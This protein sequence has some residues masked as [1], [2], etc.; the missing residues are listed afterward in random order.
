[1]FEKSWRIHSRQGFSLIEL[2]VVVGIVAILAGLLLP[3]LSKARR[4]VRLSQCFNNQRQLLLTWHLYNGDNREL[5]VANG[6]GQAGSSIALSS[7]MN[8]GAAA[9]RFWVPGD[10]HF[11]YPAFTNAQWLTDPRNAMFAP[12]LRSAVVYK[13][14][15]DHSFINV[16][17]VGKFPHIRS[18]S[19]NAYVGWAVTP[20]E[21]NPHYRVFATT[22][23]MVG[24]SSP[25]SLFVFQDVHPDN[26]CFPA[27]VVRMPGEPEQFFHYPSSL[28]NGRGVVAF[29][30]GHVETHRW[31]DPRTAP[32]VNG[33]ILAHWN[34][35]T[36]NPDLDWIRERTTFAEDTAQ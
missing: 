35:S 7:T 28:H 11:Y 31:V 5:A 33:N 30:D 23:D 27:F 8:D 4:Q 9:T 32:P 24:P 36:G 10:D 17:G 21:L 2:L 16:P 25:A 22:A 1:M 6:H 34:D 15:E 13:C 3:A 20:D 18:Y 26:I 12:Y 29:A 19:M 14:P